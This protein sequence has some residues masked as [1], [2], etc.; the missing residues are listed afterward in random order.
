MNEKIL[1]HFNALGFGEYEVKAYAALLRKG[2]MTGYQVAKTSGVPRANIYPVLK[3]LLGRGAISKTETNLGVEYH[4]LPSDE[5][6]SRLTHVFQKNIDGAKEALKSLDEIPDAPFAWNMKG[7]EAIIAKAGRMI[8]SAK[9][10]V[11]IGLWSNE[12][13]LLAPA[14][15]QALKK[16]INPTVLCIQG[17]EKEC[18][19]CQGHSYRYSMD[20]GKEHRWMVLSIDEKEALI[21]QVN[22]D[23]STV[24]THSTTEVMVTLI[25]QYLSN[26]IAVSEIVRSLGPKLLAIVDKQAMSALKGSGLSLSSESW[27]D[28]MLSAVGTTV[29]Q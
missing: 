1:K 17:C 22:K 7:Y 29:S 10:R 20:Q 11:L 5:V 19:G 21:V 28:R 15:S 24:A 9:Q 12:A 14:L 25:D 26:A 23:G 4:A 13:A 8:R 18:G 3:R 6:L 27:F 2:A 16:G